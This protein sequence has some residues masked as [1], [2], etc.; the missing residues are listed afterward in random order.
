MKK[1]IRRDGFEQ[2]VELRRAGGSSSNLERSMLSD[3]RIPCL[4]PIQ[5]QMM[6]GEECF[7]YDISGCQNLSGYYQNKEVDAGQIAQIL[8]KVLEAMEELRQYLLSGSHLL[9]TEDDVYISEDQSRIQFCYLPGHEEQAGEGMSRLVEFF[10]DHI[11]HRDEGAVVFL[12]GLYKMTKEERVSPAVLKRFLT[13]RIGKTEEQPREKPDERIYPAPPAD[14]PRPAA[15]AEDPWEKA[16]RL[17]RQRMAGKTAVWKIAG[18]VVLLFLCGLA[19]FAA[20]SIRYGAWDGNERIGTA[21]LFLLGSVCFI[22]L[23]RK[24]RG[25]EKQIE[26]DPG[27]RETAP[28]GNAGKTG[29]GQHTMVLSKTPEPH[30][31]SPVLRPVKKKGRKAIVIRKTPTVIGSLRDAVDAVIDDGSVSRI[32]ATIEMECG[33]CYVTDMQSTNGTMLNGTTL[34]SGSPMLLHKGDVL[35]FGRI[36]YSFEYESA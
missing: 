24:A 6:N 28:E 29:Q 17:S 14:M 27:D 12:Y 22:W 15:P 1:T 20:I 7:L 11:D 26:V 30:K 13:E 19:G 35:A 36:E 23:V 9:L 10:M 5:I 3:N 31:G 21:G 32:H 4:L 8:L 16:D 2:K 25:G 18:G 34:V 33:E